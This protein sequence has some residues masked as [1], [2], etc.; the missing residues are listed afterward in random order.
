MAFWKGCGLLVVIREQ[1]QAKTEKS[2]SLRSRKR[3]CPQNL[4]HRHLVGLAK[5]LAMQEH[6][7]HLLAAAPVLLV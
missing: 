3:G 5:A 4:R 7:W 2:V 1:M 6:L